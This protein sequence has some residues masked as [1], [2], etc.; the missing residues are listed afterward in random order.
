[1]SIPYERTR[2]LVQ[3][4]ELLQRLA[5]GEV[6]S[7]LRAQAEALMLHFPTLAELDAL[8]LAAPDLLGPPPPFSRLSGTGVV[9]GVIDATR[10]GHT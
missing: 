2:S 5:A 3:A 7:T 4:K 1:M 10:S 8:H 6:P 9:L